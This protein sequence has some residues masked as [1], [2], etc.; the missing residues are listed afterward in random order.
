[1]WKHVSF[2]ETY[3]KDMVDM[4]V[5]N[6]GLEE[7][8]SHKE[9]VRHE[10]LENPAGD[11][12]I[13]L[14]FDE[15]NNVLAG[16]Y[17][18]CPHI[19]KINNSIVKAILS[20]NT[21]TRKAYRGQGIFT[22]LADKA[23][24]NAKQAGYAFCY[25]APNPNSHPGFIKKLAFEDLFYMPIYVKILRPS[26]VVREKY[27]KF[28]SILAF[29]FNLFFLMRNVKDRNIVELTKDNYHI[30]DSFWNSIS[31]KYSVIGVRDANY[32]YYRYLNVPIR[33]YHPYVYLMDGKP[34]AYIV[35]RIR[36]VAGIMTG[37]IADFLF[38]D[39]YERE[40]KKLLRHTCKLVKRKKVG[41]MGCVMMENSFETKVLKKTGFFKCPKKILPQPTPMII[42]VF[43]DSIKDSG[44]LDYRKWFFTAGDYDVV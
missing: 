20:L 16:Q 8:I 5:E 33:E 23:Y 32:I 43:D 12:V 1:M 30:M 34:V 21:L 13:E 41:M 18:T 40:A 4:T 3:L 15:E 27:N 14:A 6:Y 11:P 31:S 17:V 24:E 42:R 2:N 38:I 9:F 36:P 29:P 19:F 26:T 25:G 35:T 10:Y 22:K 7:A 44:V 28:L 39:G 37:M